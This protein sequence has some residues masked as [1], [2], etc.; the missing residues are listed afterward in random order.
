MIRKEESFGKLEGEFT[1]KQVRC[2]KFLNLVRL[3]KNMIMKLENPVHL[4]VVEAEPFCFNG[5]LLIN[6][7]THKMNQKRL[8]FRRLDFDE[9]TLTELFE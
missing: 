2:P 4:Q 5:R 3:L 8:K 7:F 6:T 1:M 9:F